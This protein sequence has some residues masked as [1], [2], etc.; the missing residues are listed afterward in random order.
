LLFLLFHIEKIFGTLES[1]MYANRKFAT[2]MAPF[3]K[4]YSNERMISSI[5]SEI[6][7]MDETD[8]EAEVMAVRAKLGKE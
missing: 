7:A 3:L 4:E 6:S 2:A 1:N 8:W 5:E